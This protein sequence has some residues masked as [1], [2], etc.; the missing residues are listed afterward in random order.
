MRKLLNDNCA[1]NAQNP[2]PYIYFA[3]RQALF[4][5]GSLLDLAYQQRA[6]SF[7]K[8]DDH[9]TV[10]A[11]P[12]PEKRLWRWPMERAGGAE[13]GSS[14][15]QQLAGWLLLRYLM[16]PRV[17]ASLAEAG[18]TL[19]A[20]SS[21]LERMSDYRAAHPQWALAVGMGRPAAAGASL[22]S[23]RTVRRVEEDAAWQ[24]FS[25]ITGVSGIPAVLEE[26][27]ATAADLLKK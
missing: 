27:D 17:Q 1:W 24:I 12:S 5:S 20:R 19:P 8:S 25:P 11:Y 26:L 3:Q 16:M 14:R 9:W 10:L 23:W 18:G 2:T 4:Y 15:S 7:Q 13:V 6:M 21:A 22:A